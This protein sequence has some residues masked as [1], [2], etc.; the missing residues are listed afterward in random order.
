MGHEMWL[1]FWNITYLT[2]CWN[3]SKS[4]F[5]LVN[6]NKLK[7]FIPSNKPKDDYVLLDPCSLLHRMKRA[8]ASLWNCRTASYHLAWMFR[9]FIEFTPTLTQVTTQ[10]APFY[11]LYDAEQVLKLA[12]RREGGLYINFPKELKSCRTFWSRYLKLSQKRTQRGAAS[13]LLKGTS[14]C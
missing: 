3:K 1:K 5:I 2:H 12:K 4:F 6:M 13:Q 8:S 9:L 11:L 7:H 14:E 10:R